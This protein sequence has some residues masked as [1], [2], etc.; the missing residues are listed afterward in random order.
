MNEKICSSCEIPQSTLSS[1][2]KFMKLEPNTIGSRG[3]CQTCLDNIE[4]REEIQVET[5]ITE[6]TMNESTIN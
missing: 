6:G 1:Y 5:W 4:L 2:A 3:I